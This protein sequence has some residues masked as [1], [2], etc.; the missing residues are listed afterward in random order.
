MYK[1]L[2]V[3]FTGQDDLDNDKMKLED[4]IKESP[5]ALKKVLSLAGNRY[6]AFNNR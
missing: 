1:N 4:F 6:L 2:I 5:P 3:L